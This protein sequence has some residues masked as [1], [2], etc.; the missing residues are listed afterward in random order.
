VRRIALIT[1]SLALIASACAE[2][3]ADPGATTPTDAST[4]I[5]VSPP[6]SAPDESTV[7]TTSEAPSPSTT[8]AADTTGAASTTSTSA[9][10]TQA[11]TT[12]TTSTTVPPT[13]EAPIPL[14]E[15][16]LVLTEVASGFRQPVFVDAP[17]G[18]DRLWVVDQV[19]V[20]YLVADGAASV[21]VDL[22]DRVTFGG[23]RGLLGLAFHPGFDTNGRFFVHYSG[24]GGATVVEEHRVGTDPNAAEPDSDQLIFTT[25][26]PASNHNGG[27]IA[28]GPDGYLYIALG[29]GGGADD[30]YGNGQNRD[31]P[32]G[33]ILRIDVD[34][35][36]PYAVPAENPFADGGGVPEIWAFGLRNPWRFSFD[37]DAVWIADVGQRLWEEIDRVD[38]RDRG[39]NFGWPIMEGFNCFQQATC[40]EAGLTLPILEYPHADGACSIT[41]GYVYRGSSI[42]QLEGAYFYGDFCTGV[43]SSFFVDGE[44]VFAQ[45]VW[46]ELRTPGLTSFGTDGAGE[47]YL[48]STS[49][50]VYRVEQRT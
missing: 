37:G 25:P 49:G 29:D 12:T 3:G 36:D 30:R 39:L 32:L 21:F 35:G 17:A 2:N 22:T 40:S 18:D 20:V 6:T 47:L 33:A 1:T 38:H 46:E 15:T 19:G 8:D 9:P 48:T 14:D 27:M 43:V 41:G 5:S 16:E 13:T 42:P 31:T 28:F 23:E 26:Q 44:G 4:S 7:S 10:T 11:T 50:A 34:G 24:A 45:R